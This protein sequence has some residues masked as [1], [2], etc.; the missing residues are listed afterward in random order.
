MIVK[1]CG[2][3]TLE[4]AKHAVENGA[5]FLGIIL[6]PNRQRTISNET[7]CEISKYLNSL[8]TPRPKLVGVF[9]NQS[10]EEIQYL[11][12]LIGLDVIQLH[13]NETVDL[14]KSI[15]VPVVRRLVPESPTLLEDAKVLQDLQ[16]QVT[17]L[18]DSEQGGDGKLVNWNQLNQLANNGYH[19]ILAGGLT[20]ENVHSAS[21]QPGC[22]GV[23]VSGGVET[24]GTKDLG[25]IELFL[26]NAKI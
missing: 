23:D 22:I 15:D 16:Q 20:P 25:K 19:Y 13:G 21:T 12:N 18:I 7:A 26:K 5:D 14:V 3:Q 2:L 6:V 11:Q 10:L 24:N 4:A 17:L 9:R 1:I 8:P